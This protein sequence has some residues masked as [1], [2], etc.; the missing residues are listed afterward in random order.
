MSARGI[1]V[2]G[3]VCLVLVAGGCLSADLTAPDLPA[4][5]ALPPAPAAASQPAQ[6][7]LSVAVVSLR[8]CLEWALANNLRLSVERLTPSLRDAQIVEALSAFDAVFGNTYSYGSLRQESGQSPF[9]APPVDRSQTWAVDWNVQKRLLTGAQAKIA[10]GWDHQETNNPFVTPDPRQDATLSAGVTQPLLRDFGRDVNTAAIRVARNTKYGSDYQF[11]KTVE[12]TLQGVEE[13][14][15][16][17]YAAIEQLKVRKRQLDR[18]KDLLDRAK[19]LVAAGKSARV[20]ETAAQAEVA[21]VAGTIVQAENT[22]RRAEDAI[23]RQINHPLLPLGARTRVIPADG[24]G[25]APLAVDVD[26]A[27]AEALTKR[28]DL[29]AAEFEQ[30]SADI[31]VKVAQNQLLPRLD[32]GLSHVLHGLDRN[33]SGALEDLVD[34]QFADKQVSLTLQIPL[35]NRAAKSRLNQARIGRE[36]VVRSIGDLRQQIV[37]EVVRILDDA[38]SDHAQIT[39]AREATRLAQERLADEEALYR[40]ERSTRTDVLQAQTDV[41]E[42][43]LDEIRAIISYNINISRFYR[44]EGAYLEQNRIVIENVAGN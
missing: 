11:R 36:Q 35:G 44:L 9:L 8:Q 22:V 32:L 34:G 14:Y 6:P 39:A 7:Q 21:R 12:D 38:G 24:P 13:T 31:R 37:G 17:L 1:A 42:R 3:R 4:M 41:A 27:V 23:K 15:W 2:V 18:A 43:E 33:T 30:A 5:T 16:L 10:F 20:D 29:K 28:P 40:N 19:K 26:K 25:D